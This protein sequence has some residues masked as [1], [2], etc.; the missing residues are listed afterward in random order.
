MTLEQMFESVME[1]EFLQFARIKN[2]LH[3]RPDVCGFLLLHE[4]Q[5]AN[6]DMIDGAWHDEYHLAIDCDELEKV[7]TQEQVITLVRCGVRYDDEQC[8]LVVFS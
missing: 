3:P 1:E 4:L 2:P 6:R 8:G 5:P 7:I